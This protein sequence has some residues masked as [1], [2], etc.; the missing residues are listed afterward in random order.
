[1]VEPSKSLP[2]SEASPKL[3]I[4]RLCRQPL[5]LE[6]CKVDADGQPM[7]EACYVASLKSPE[8]NS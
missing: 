8:F 6:T 3:A 7:H 4:C 2:S 5:A 1:M